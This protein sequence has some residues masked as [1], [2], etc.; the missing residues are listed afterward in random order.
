MY[1]YRMRKNSMPKLR[2]LREGTKTN[3]YFQ[4]IVC[5]RRVLV[6]LPTV[7]LGQTEF[8]CQAKPLKYSE[9]KSYFVPI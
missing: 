1:V 4:G 9:E 5:R 6:A 8:G 7:K 3:I 2:E